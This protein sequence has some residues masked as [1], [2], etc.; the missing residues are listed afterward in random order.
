MEIKKIKIVEWV[1]ASGR[2]TGYNPIPT[3]MA[4]DIYFCKLE[5]RI[6]IKYIDPRREDLIEEEIKRVLSLN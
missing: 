2:D 3:K 5:D 6:T 4:V 1:D